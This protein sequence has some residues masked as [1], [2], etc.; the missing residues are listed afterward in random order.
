MKSLPPSSPS[1]VVALILWLYLGYAASQVTAYANSE[2]VRADFDMLDFVDPLIGTVNGG[3][4]A[5][6]SCC[7]PG[8]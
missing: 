5:L 6:S 2:V 4:M 1:G 7:T 8:D 3:K